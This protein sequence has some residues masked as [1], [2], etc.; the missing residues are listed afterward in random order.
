MKQNRTHLSHLSRY[1]VYP[2]M[3]N[4]LFLSSHLKIE[5]KMPSHVPKFLQRTKVNTNRR[6]FSVV[7]FSIKYII[8]AIPTQ[9]RSNDF[10][11]VGEYC[12]KLM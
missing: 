5:G 12:K 6:G 9:K 3:N 10:N 11:V 8:Y 4:C 7:L 2:S 1:S